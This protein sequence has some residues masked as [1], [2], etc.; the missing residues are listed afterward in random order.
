MPRSRRTIVL[1][2]SM[3]LLAAPVAAAQKGGRA[4]ALRGQ[5]I[6]IVSPRFIATAIKF[7]ALDETGWDR[8]GSDEVHAVFA[9]WNPFGEHATSVFENVDSGDT[10]NFPA[11]QN[12]IAPQPKCDRGASSLHFA[13]A[14]WESDWSLSE[15]IWGLEKPTLA[16]SHEMYAHGI[17]T[18][19]DLIGRSEINLTTAELQAMLPAVGS[20]VDTTVKPAGGSGSYQFTYRIT[21]LPNVERTIVIHVPPVSIGGIT[22]TATL[23]NQPRRVSL[24]WS[25]ATGNNVDILRGA[26]LIATTPNDGQ[27]TDRVP[28]AGTYQYRV[29]NAGMTTCSAVASIAVP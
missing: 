22:L 13:V 8:W 9:D 15:A 21:R 11:A 2:V 1:W 18:G 12:C 29:C 10:K 5:E 20:S 19:D 17:D 7:K 24:N 26:A 25:N 6:H 27:Y 14:L 23:E 3:A 4:Q 16:N 28:A